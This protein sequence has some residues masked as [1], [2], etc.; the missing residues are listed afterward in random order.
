M[1]EISN[2]AEIL[3]SKEERCDYVG[4]SEL[5]VYRCHKCARLYCIEHSSEID[6]IRWCAECMDV[7]SCDVIEMPLVDAEGVRHKGRVI[8]PVGRAFIEQNKLISELTDE[9]LKQFIVEYQRLLQDAE[10][11]TNLYKISLTQATHTAL[12]REILKQKPNGPPGEF[13]FATPAARPEKK[14]RSAAKSPEDRLV[15]AMAKAGVT[16]EMILK[17]LADR[18]ANKK[19]G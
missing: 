6:P 2:D 14:T 1:T 3:A 16:P 4:C 5:A 9:E 7:T 19:A 12:D 10:K 18:K 17:M 13:Y 8:R 11:I 15:A